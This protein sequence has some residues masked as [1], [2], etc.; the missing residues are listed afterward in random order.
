MIGLL[1]VA[2]AIRPEKTNP[3]VD[4]N[5]ALHA[6]AEVMSILKASCY[7]CHSH[8]TKWPPYSE[9]APLSWSIVAHVNDARKAMNFSKWESIDKEIKTKRLKRAIQTVNNGMMPLPS[10]LRFHEEAQLSDTQKATI[11][12]W[13]NQEL[14]K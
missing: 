6:P 3:P 11:V 8:E 10:Y 2:Q 9:I 13:C 7:D 12:E 5:I 1:L 14:A 4:E